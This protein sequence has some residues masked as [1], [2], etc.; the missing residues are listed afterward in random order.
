MR[1]IKSFIS[2]FT[3]ITTTVLALVGITTAIEGYEHLSKYIL[4]QILASGAATA[5]IT[6]LILCREIRT[7][8]QF[9][10]LTALHYVLLCGTMI[11]L[12]VWFDWIESSFAGIVE[13]AAYVAVVYVVVFLTTYFLRKREADAI[14][15]ALRKRNNKI[16]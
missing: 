2:Y 6:T 12:G 3:T 4:F 5:F 8:K 16:S 7:R 1:F 9:L 14:N 13:M 10:L 15:R 11:G